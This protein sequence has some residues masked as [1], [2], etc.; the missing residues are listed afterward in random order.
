VGV[1]RD[2]MICA[3]NGS[4]MMLC[5]LYLIYWDWNWWAWYD[6]TYEKW[7]DCWLNIGMRL[8]CTLIL[9]LV[10][11]TWLWYGFGHNSMNL[12]VRLL[13]L[14]QVYQVA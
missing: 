2:W 4:S 7:W 14:W 10:S 9:W 5:M 11:E 6:C 3:L 13:R 1:S 8:L 12:L